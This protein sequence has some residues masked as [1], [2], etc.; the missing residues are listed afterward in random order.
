LSATNPNPSYIN[1]YC[2]VATVINYTGTINNIGC[3]T[4]SGAWTNNL[5]GNGGWQWYKSCNAPFVETSASS[6]IWGSGI[7]GAAHLWF[8]DLSNE[9]DWAGRVVK[10]D[11]FSPGYDSCQRDGDIANGIYPYALSG[12]NWSVGF[13]GYNRYGLDTIGFSALQV[14]Y[15]RDRNRAPCFAGAPQTMQIAC[16]TL[17]SLTFINYQDNSLNVGI[18][19][20]TV[21]SGRGTQSVTKVYP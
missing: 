17:Q 10:E 1:P 7:T 4:A 5:G 11:Q 8:G 9:I 2:Q 18:G 13:T 21:S 19:T 12:G 6:G 14:S 15:Y 3:N 16:G 20:N